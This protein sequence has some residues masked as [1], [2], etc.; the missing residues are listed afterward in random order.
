MK[1][2]AILVI[3]LFGMLLW[4]C[5]EDETIRRLE[6]H[7]DQSDDKDDKTD[8]EEQE[9]ENEEEEDN[10]EEEE[11]DT[12][13]EEGP[14]PVPRDP[15]DLS[16]N[17]TLGEVAYFGAATD[18]EKGF[19]RAVVEGLNVFKLENPTSKQVRFRV[20]TDKGFY[21]VTVDPE[22]MVIVKGQAGEV[23][24][25][26]RAYNEANE[27]IW[28]HSGTTTLGPACSDDPVEEDLELVAQ[29]SCEGEVGDVWHFGSA[30]DT[31]RGFVRAVMEGY[32]V[33]KLE[34]P[35]TDTIRFEVNT[36][37]SAYEVWVNPTSIVIVKGIGGEVITLVKAYNGTTEMWSKGGT[38]TLGPACTTSPEDPVAQLSCEGEIGDVMVF[39]EATDTER[40][41]VRS[42]IEGYDV[43]K[44]ENP[45]T[46]VIRFIVITTGG[47]IYDV[48]VDPQTIVIVKGESGRVIVNVKAFNGADLVWVKWGTATLGPACGS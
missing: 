25:N 20:I 37:L 6:D 26:V 22:T 9:E 30:T 40:G 4:A 43:F 45:T 28:N 16:C 39:G 44:L 15:V 48:F 24:L 32:D 35:T 1:R 38:A 27:E 42:V 29:L 13:E 3:L 8:E 18:T 47:G 7:T 10:E 36:N 21:E 46:D 12:D 5:N 41:F 2:S 17:G 31:E 14:P 34:N 11:E 23:I 33:F 19:I